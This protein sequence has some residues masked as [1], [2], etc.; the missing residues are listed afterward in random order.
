L[1]LRAAGATASRWWDYVVRDPGNV[2]RRVD[3]S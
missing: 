3:A 2:L 1:M